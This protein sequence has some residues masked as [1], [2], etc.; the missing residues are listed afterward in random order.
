[1][2]QQPSQ[3]EINDYIQKNVIPGFMPLLDMNIKSA[4][5]GENGDLI[6]ATNKLA[7]AVGFADYKQIQGLSVKKLLILGGFKVFVEKFPVLEKV[8]LLLI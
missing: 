3:V 7:N 6:I 2:K 1:M 8:F 5:W 4:L